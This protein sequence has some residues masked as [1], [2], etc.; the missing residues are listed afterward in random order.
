MAQMRPR[1]RQLLWL[2]QFLRVAAENVLGRGEGSEGT[3]L[4]TVASGTKN[5]VVD[6]PEVPRLKFAPRQLIHASPASNERDN[7]G[8]FHRALPKPTRTTEH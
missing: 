6:G 4:L 5:W 7:S 3:R 2:A 8:Q 1:D